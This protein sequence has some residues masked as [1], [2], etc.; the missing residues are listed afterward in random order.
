MGQ[1]TGSSRGGR[2][3]VRHREVQR[4]QRRLSAIHPGR[5][6]QEPL[7]VGRRILELENREQRGAS[8]LLEA[9]RKFV[10]IQR[11][12]WRSAIAAG[13]ASLLEPRGSYCL[14]ELAGKK[15]GER[16]AVS[17][18]DIRKPQ[19]VGNEKILSLGQ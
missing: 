13:L 16:G 15:I 7:I 5:W 1:R 8:R 11:Y 18:C 4:N 19:N 17:S 9:R 14:R 10:A 6:L 3:G 12:V 2:S